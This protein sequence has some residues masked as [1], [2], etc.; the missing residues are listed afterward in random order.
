MALFLILAFIVT[1]LVELYVFFRVGDAIGFLP[2]IGILFVVS[3]LGGTLV[4]R[5]GMRA[6]RA[7]T[8][9]VGGGRIPGREVADAALVLVG[10]TL[11]L[12]PGF[13]TDALGFLLVLPFSRPLARRYLARFA[14][15]RAHVTVV[16]PGAAGRRTQEPRVMEGEIIDGEVVDD[17]PAQ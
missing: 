3:I 5:E 14:A 4:R 16:G 11:L 13:V 7:F 8:A 2:T 15:R 17:P 10:G 1:P 12:T 9:A 6:W